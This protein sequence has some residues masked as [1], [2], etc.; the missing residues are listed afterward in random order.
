MSKIDFETILDE[1]KTVMTANLNTRISAITAEKGSGV[2]LRTID[3]AAYFLQ[4]LDSRPAM[5]DPF[6]FYGISNIEGDGGHSA[7]PM[8]LTMF[9]IIVCSDDGEDDQTAR[10]MFRYQRALREIFEE[11]FELPES[12]VKLSVSSLVPVEVTLL[13]TTQSHRAIGVELVADLG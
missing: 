11:N 13:N 7:T 3:S 9:C 4:T 2:S 12:S 6:V 8:K 1:V 5:F 10:R